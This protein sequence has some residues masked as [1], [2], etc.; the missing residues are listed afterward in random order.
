MEGIEALW[1]ARKV[2]SIISVP[3]RTVYSLADSG[4]LPY[5]RVGKR[6]LR[7]RPE[8]IKALVT[9]TRRAEY[10]GGAS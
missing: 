8:D 10:W 6:L 2:A 1:D 7:F 3:V 4:V 9:S 5:V